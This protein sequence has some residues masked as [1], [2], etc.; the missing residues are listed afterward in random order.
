M[1]APDSH[2]NDDEVVAD[3]TKVQA[4]L[5]LYIRSLMPGDPSAEE[6]VQQANAKIWQKR[7]E[8]QRGTSFRAWA[9]AIARFEVLNHRKQ[10]ARD[11]R[12]LQF[13]DELEQ[14]IA[15][16]AAELGDDLAERQQAL[17]KCLAELK[18]ES[19]DLLM[20]RYESSETLADFALRVGRSVGGLRVTLTR[21]R[22]V[23]AQCIERRISSHHPTGGQL[24]SDGGAP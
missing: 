10:Q 14:I 3:L 15:V 23:L 1:D 11:A 20:S 24:H 4:A 19:R 12:R 21:L 13:S 17:H 22:S 5:V 2:S 7:T 16:E 9:T 18:Q 8:Y 6:V